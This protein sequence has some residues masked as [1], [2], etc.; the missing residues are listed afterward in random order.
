MQVTQTSKGDPAT[1][2]AILN[3]LA[4]TN[5]VQIVTKS[6]SAGSFIIVS[7]NAAP[8]GQTAEVL[9]GDPA[10]ISTLL[11]ALIGGGATIEILVTTF[12]GGYY[13]VV[14]S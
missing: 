6:R 14:Y 11:A 13:V 4:A 10:T 1:L 3:T 9:K 12:S 7:D 8:T 5:E 2:A